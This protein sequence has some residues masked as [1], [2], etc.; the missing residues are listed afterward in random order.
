MPTVAAVMEFL[1]AFAPLQ[2][3]ADWDNVGL[4]H[5]RTCRYRRERLVT[6]T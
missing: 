4:L 5:R 2:L 1:E 3:A 6:C